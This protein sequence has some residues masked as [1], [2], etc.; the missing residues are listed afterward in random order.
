M[1]VTEKNRGTKV[2]ELEKAFWDRF[3]LVTYFQPIVSIKKKTV[4]GFEALTRA[5]DRQDNVQISYADLKNFVKTQQDRLWLDR[6]CR[7]CALRAWKKWQDDFPESLLFLNFDVDVLNQGV[8]GSNVLLDTVLECGLSPN[9]IVVELVEQRVQRDDDLVAFVEKYRHHGFLIAIDDFGE[10]SSNLERLFLI[11]PDVIKISKRLLDA[12]RYT[13]EYGKSVLTGVANFITSLGAIAL[14]EGVETIHHLHD[15]VDCN[16]DVIQGYLVARPQENIGGDN[17]ELLQ[18]NLRKIVEIAGMHRMKNIQ[19]SRMKSNYILQEARHLAQLIEQVTEPT[20][21]NEMLARFTA[22]EEQFVCIYL[23]SD[24]GRQIS[25][26]FFRER[27][28]W[29]NALYR[30]ARVGDDH[31]EKDYFLYIKAGSDQYYSPPYISLA[32]GSFCTTIS[33]AIKRGVFSGTVFCVD[34]VV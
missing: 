20:D 6:S 11:R 31:S 29:K 7:R 13:E 30:P 17:G 8:L 26:T 16:I 22:L 23:L 34:F 14:V 4:I 12:P 19:L 5:W 25:D 2:V 3:E 10:D 32:T 15:A 27:L 21:P 1:N 9:L 33:I 28:D 18:E 24:K